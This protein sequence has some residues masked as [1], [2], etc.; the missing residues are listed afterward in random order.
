MI[1]TIHK[2]KKT[3]SIK[4]KSKLIM[5]VFSLRISYEENWVNNADGYAPAAVN[6]HTQNC[7]RLRD[8]C[9]WNHRSF[10][11]VPPPALLQKSLLVLEVSIVLY[12]SQLPS[13]KCIKPAIKTVVS[14]F[15]YFFTLFLCFY[16]KFIDTF[17]FL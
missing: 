6:V 5:F 17:F 14:M 10:E 3:K 16:I 11:I 8:S 12:D 13:Q 15:N 4:N 7:D 9:K 2:K 1:K